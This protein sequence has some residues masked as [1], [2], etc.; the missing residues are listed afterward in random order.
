MM[1]YRICFVVFAPAIL[2]SILVDSCDEVNI[3]TQ[4]QCKTAPLCP[5]SRRNVRNCVMHHGGGTICYCFP[6]C[7]NNIHQ[8]QRSTICDRVRCAYYPSNAT[9]TFVHPT[10][11]CNCCGELIDNCVLHQLISRGC[12]SFL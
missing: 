10:G 3:C 12:R 6:D 9:H 4:E 8:C 7:V 2:C 11:K 5:S 1:S